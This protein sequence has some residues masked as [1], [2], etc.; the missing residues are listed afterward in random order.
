MCL[1]KP[2]YFAVALPSPLSPV[3]SALSIHCSASITSAGTLGTIQAAGLA[4][5]VLLS[6]ADE[7]FSGK[8]EFVKSEFICRHESPKSAASGTLILDIL[9]SM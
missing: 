6:S 2:T 7:K 5:T 1:G 4:C 9:G 3:A 8:Q